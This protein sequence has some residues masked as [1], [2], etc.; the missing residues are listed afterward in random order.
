[1]EEV[2]VN[3][4]TFEIDP[5]EPIDI[6]PG[7]SAEL[8]V[9]VLN[10]SGMYNY[11]WETGETTPSIIVTPLK[12]SIYGITVE[13]TENEC[14]AMGYVIVDWLDTPNI[15]IISGTPSLC[16][17]DL[18]MLS[19]QEA[20][21]PENTVLL[22]EGC[23]RQSSILYAG[24][25]IP[26]FSYTW[27]TGETTDQIEV[28][29]PGIYSVT[30]TKDGE[31]CSTIDSYEISSCA[32]V[33]IIPGF[34]ILENSILDAGDNFVNYK[35]HDGSTSQTIEI[36]TEGLYS[37]TVTD[38]NECEAT[39]SIEIQKE[40]NYSPEDLYL[41][42]SMIDSD[43]SGAGSGKRTVFICN[44]GSP[45]D[46]I[47]A[48]I[49]KK[50]PSGINDLVLWDC[51]PMSTSEFQIEKTNPNLRIGGF[52]IK[53]NDLG[54]P[55][56][57]PHYLYNNAKWVNYQLKIDVSE[58][59]DG[60]E[61]INN[62]AVFQLPGSSTFP[63]QIV[64]DLSI[65]AEGDPTGPT[66]PNYILSPNN[67]MN[68]KFVENT[69]TTN[70]YRLYYSMDGVPE[71]E[72][73]GEI[74]APES[75]EINFVI[76]KIEN[77]M[78]IDLPPG[79]EVFWVGFTGGIYDNQPS[80]NYTVP[81]FET[82]DSQDPMPQ[83]VKINAF[84]DNTYSVMANINVT[85]KPINPGIHVMDV[86]TGVTVPSDGSSCSNT[87]LII[88][89][90][91][92]DAVNTI[93]MDNPAMYNL[94]A[95]KEINLILT[96]HNKDPDFKEQEKL[97]AGYGYSKIQFD[98]DNGRIHFDPSLIKKEKDYQGGSNKYSDCPRLEDN[99]ISPVVILI[100][101][102]EREMIINAILDTNNDIPTPD[103][104][105]KIKM[106]YSP[107]GS[108]LES[109]CDETNPTKAKDYEI[110]LNKKRD[111]NKLGY[112][113]PFAELNNQIGSEERG[114][115]A[116]NIEN[117]ENIKRYVELPGCPSLT[118][119]Q[120]WNI[121]KDRCTKIN[122]LRQK[123]YN[124]TVAHEMA[125]IFFQLENPALAYIWSEFE[126]SG[127][128]NS[129][130][131]GRVEN[132]PPSGYCSNGGGHFWNNPDGISTCG[133]LDDYPAPRDNQCN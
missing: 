40:Y 92:Q 41:V 52:F 63:D 33:E 98:Y 76:K 44:S 50:F 38:E 2:Q 43:N 69:G 28:Y 1:V 132:S 58:L 102:E 29:N 91:V 61:T 25:G 122:G 6:C 116:I 68:I 36:T 15:K 94:V 42:F 47:E 95:S 127:D 67:T 99:N 96:S 105:T 11:L 131:P 120:W 77:G 39:N 126:R 12:S 124:T 7:E 72:V 86:S 22:T 53:K 129:C 114:L 3:V 18:V 73:T 49:L 30:V 89:Q 93:M 103:V 34:N 84:I 57:P 115:I 5:G 31:P 20:K 101:N 45:D 119:D 19:S 62:G 121:N 10:G 81:A 112:R 55:Y 35:W 108:I 54:E 100:T 9:T 130:Y 56:L 37:V 97:G 78:A 46:E 32:T 104:V 110:D 111:A 65:R 59:T 80:I 90:K 125:H 74:S 24:T 87:S 82:P 109:Y 23:D 79:T 16:V 117:H 51:N 123:L 21:Q 107:L 66:P 13:D 17:T 26:G 85:E 88:K 14:S 133:A 83:I 27:S 106:V 75:T 64:T 4:N 118:R 60:F 71:Q 8:S 128:K 113:I 70:P 48:F